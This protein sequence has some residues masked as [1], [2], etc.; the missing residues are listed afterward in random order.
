MSKSIAVKLK[1]RHYAHYV[2]YR[3]S[4]DVVYDPRVNIHGVILGADELGPFPYFILL[5]SNLVFNGLPGS[6]NSQAPKESKFGDRD[7]SIYPSA[8]RCF[9]A[10]R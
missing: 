6:F 3:F 1:Q 4:W 7:K 9:A 10:F 8:F 2:S 5:L